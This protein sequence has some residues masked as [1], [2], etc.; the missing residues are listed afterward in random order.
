MFRQ[1]SGG[2]AIFLAVPPFFWRF[3][4]FLQPENM[5]IKTGT[6]QVALK[7]RYLL[8]MGVAHRIRNQKLIKPL[9][10]RNMNLFKNFHYPVAP[11]QGLDDGAV[12]IRRSLPCADRLCPFRA[13]SIATKKLL[14]LSCHDR[15]IHKNL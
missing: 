14:I 15:H 11:F 3:W 7:G 10:G 4:R 9:Q 13:T 5:H 2:S 8:T 6:I 1:K 12:F